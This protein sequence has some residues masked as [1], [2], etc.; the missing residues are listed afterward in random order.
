MRSLR[1]GEAV[2]FWEQFLKFALYAENALRCAG[3]PIGELMRQYAEAHPSFAPVTECVRRWSGG[4][5][6]PA[7]WAAGVDSL[8]RTNRL[9]E[10]AESLLRGFGAGLGTTDL[11]GQLSHIAM[12]RALGEEKRSAARQEQESKSKMYPVLG[13]ALGLGLDLLLL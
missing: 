11:T 7:A 12:Y 13:A 3:M 4:E 1:L 2:R 9:P 6:L 5:E 8:Y 10:T